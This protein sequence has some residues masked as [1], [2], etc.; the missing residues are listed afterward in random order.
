[1]TVGSPPPIV[2]LATLN[3]VVTLER[4]ARDSISGIAPGYYD[5][6]QIQMSMAHLFGIDTMLVSDGTYFV[7]EIDEF[8]VACGGWSKRMTPFG[9]D[10]VSNVRDTGF[11]IPG[12]DPAV[13]RAFFV[14]PDHTRKGLGRLMLSTCEEAA[15]RAGYDRLELTSTSMGRE[16]Y[17]ACGYHEIEPVDIALPENV[18]LPNFLMRKP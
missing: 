1:M 7:V 3:D 16:F 15:Y 18:V 14:H 13:I 11:R 4:L 8:I 12:K 10:R 9:G 5:E 17:A 2:R 6:K